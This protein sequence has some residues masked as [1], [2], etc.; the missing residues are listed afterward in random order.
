MEEKIDSRF[1]SGLFQR[2]VASKG[3]IQKTFQKYPGEVRR[4]NFLQE[5]KEFVEFRTE[6][7]NDRMVHIGNGFYLHYVRSHSLYFALI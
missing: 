5:K 7:L 2:F 6:K 4:K 1:V 3:R